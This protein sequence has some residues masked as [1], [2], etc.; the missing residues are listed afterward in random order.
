MSQSS[1][2]LLLGLHPLKRGGG[3]ASAQTDVL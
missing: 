3:L 2:A 1:P